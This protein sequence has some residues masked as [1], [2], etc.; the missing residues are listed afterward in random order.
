MND[1]TA[2][3]IGGEF[4]YLGDYVVEAENKRAKVDFGA[5]LGVTMGVMYVF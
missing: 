5:T 4:Q 1:V 2:L 3:Y